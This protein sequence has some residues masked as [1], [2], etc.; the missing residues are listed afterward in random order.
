[1]IDI[2]DEYFETHASDL[3]HWLPDGIVTVDVKLLADMGLLE[4]VTNAQKTNELPQCMYAVETEDRITLYND[5]FAAWVVPTPT[6]GEAETLLLIATLSDTTPKLEAGFLFQGVH[7][8]A[9]TILQVLEKTIQDIRETNKELS[10]IVVDKD[11][12]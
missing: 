11:P 6:N 4:N 3:A 7:N 9:K 2:L 1:M 5:F 12:K 8:Q 10:H